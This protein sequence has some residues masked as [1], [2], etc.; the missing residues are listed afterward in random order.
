MKHHLSV[1]AIAAIM[2]GCVADTQRSSHFFDVS[3]ADQLP[4]ANLSDLIE[5]VRVVPLE[6]ND[7]VV[8]GRVRKTIKHNGR[9]Y[10]YAENGRTAGMGTISVF[11]ANTGRFM[12]TIGQRGGGPGE[13]APFTLIDFAVTDTSVM[14]T[15]G[16][17]R[18]LSY[19]PDGQFASAYTLSVA[20]NNIVALPASFLTYS[21]SDSLNWH[22][23]SPAG[24]ELMAL[25]PANA[26]SNIATSNRFLEIDGGKLMEATWCNEARVYDPTLNSYSDTMIADI[27]DVQTLARYE[28]TIALTEFGTMEGK[29]EGTLINSIST[30][31]VSKMMITS[32]PDFSAFRLWVAT[33]SATKTVAIA[34]ITDDVTGDSDSKL[35]DILFGN[36]TRDGYIAVID[37]ESFG[38]DKDKMDPLIAAAIES[39][40]L[41]PESNPV[42]V[43]YRL[44]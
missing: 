20:A 36:G 26:L 33:P 11:D 38:T 24:N 41:T 18:M 25:A 13:I 39:S 34:D 37:A 16:S 15:D 4:S 30:D 43:E 3:N 14:V 23:Y 21:Q 28:Q 6:N 19:S 1:L 8:I 12:H 27:P 29:R 35:P 17:N 10:V 7:S 9:Y 22:I 32:A 31:G 42:V 5:V 40:G 44:R 2:S